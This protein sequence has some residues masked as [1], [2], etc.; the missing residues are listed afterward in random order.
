MGRAISRWWSSFSLWAEVA[1]GATGVL[2]L[3]DTASSRFPLQL[4]VTPHI[5]RHCTRRAWVPVGQ[6]ENRQPVWCLES[7]RPC[8]VAALVN[9][10]Y[11]TFD[12][13]CDRDRG[14]LQSSHGGKE[15]EKR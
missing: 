8:R 4:E 3:Y 11:E 6:A 13:E 1:R 10:H 15:G 12:Q 2:Q 7:H 14:R 5:T 9:C